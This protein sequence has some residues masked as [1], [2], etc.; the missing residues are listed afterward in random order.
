MFCP[1]APAPSSRQIGD[2]VSFRFFGGRKRR[3][4]QNP[5]SINQSISGETKVIWVLSDCQN[6]LRTLSKLLSDYFWSICCTAQ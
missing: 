2:F 4:W 3:F 5:S 1:P 6:E